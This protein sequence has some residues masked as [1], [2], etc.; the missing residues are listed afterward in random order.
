MWWKRRRLEGLIAQSLHEDLSE[1]DR[2]Y[3][4]RELASH[5]ELAGLADQLRLFVAEIPREAIEPPCDVFPGV[6]ARLAETP[7]RSAFVPTAAAVAV[8]SL[9]AIVAGTLFLRDGQ[10][11]PGSGTAPIIAR[12]DLTGVLEQAEDLTTRAEYTAA[13][14]LLAAGIVSH[15][16]DPLAGEVQLRIAE[17]AFDR[18]WYPQ[19]YEAVTKLRTEYPS[20]LDTEPG[21][22][23][24]VTALHELL[25]EARAV[26]YVSLNEWQAARHERGDTL[27][28]LERVIA[29]YPDAPFLVQVAA[30][31]MATRIAESQGMTIAGWPDHIR[32][33]ETAR[34]MCADP[35]A[36]AQLD[37]ELGHLYRDGVHDS[38]LASECYRRAAEVPVLAQRANEALST[39]DASAVQ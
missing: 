4:D 7:R 10:S 32:A 6:L 22:R 18:G 25:D 39:L 26:D 23:S 33:L 8:C 28:A 15:P 20:T 34:T 16:T 21:R 31:D 3:L 19:A 27:K 1:T 2:A 29:R 11:A 36:I 12:S 5:P 14:Q 37:I 17:L 30:K 9:V 38:S 13:Y 24:H 35:V